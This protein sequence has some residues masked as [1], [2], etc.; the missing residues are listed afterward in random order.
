MADEPKPCPSCGGS[1]LTEHT[2]HEVETDENGKQRSVTR[3]WTGPCNACHG[4]G[5]CE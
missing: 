5:R 2:R 4:S 1:G 3:S